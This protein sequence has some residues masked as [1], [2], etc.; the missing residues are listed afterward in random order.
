MIK[1]ERN[2]DGSVVGYWDINI[3]TILGVTVQNSI[4]GK[5]S[6]FLKFEIRF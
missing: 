5:F 6:R 3:K 2:Y 4:I 1:I